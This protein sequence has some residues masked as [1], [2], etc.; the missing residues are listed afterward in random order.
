MRVP[1]SWLREFAPTDM[2]ADEL[3]DLITS[4]GVKVEAVLRPWE[5]L[6]GVVVARVIEVRDHPNSQ[7]LCLV[8]V[9]RGGGELELVAGIRN[10]VAG[11]LVPLAPP[12][13]RVPVLDE[14]LG[15]RE[16]RGA[17]SNGM[18]C[19]SREL[20]ISPDHG[21]IL[22]LN[23]EKLRPG[24]DLKQAL[25][26]DDAVLDIEVEPNRPDF[27]S[28]FGVA[29]EV[30]AMAGVALKPPDLSLVEDA[31][32]ASSVASVRLDAPD[33]C[34]RYVGRILRGIGA[35][36]TPISAQA[37][38]TAA[39]MRPLSPVVDATNYTMLELGQP[40]HAFDLQGLAGPGIVVRRAERGERLTTLDG[41]DRTMSDED[42]LICDLKEPVALAGVMGGATSEVCATTTDV[43]LEAA[44]FTRTGILRTARRL[45]LH[46]EASHRFERGSDR[47]ALD[48]AGTR[49]AG[50]IAAWTGARVLAGTA[51]A[52][53]VQE[54]GW[55]S[56]R[57]ERASAL[58]GHEVTLDQ[59][60]AVFSELGLASRPGAGGALEVEIPGYRVDIEREVDLIEEIA[61]MR[62]YDEIG[63]TLPD[64][65]HVG[66]LPEPYRFAREVKGA[67]LRAGLREVRPLPFASPEDLA[68]TGDEDGIELSNP[69]RAEEGFMRTRL[70]PGLLH[71]I[72][73]NQALGVRSLSLFEVSTVFRAGDPI[74]ER[75]KIAFAM[76]GKAPTAWWRPE[77][78]LDALDIKGVLTSLMQEVRVGDWRLGDSLG[79]PFH[80][81]RSAEIL[82]RGE[83]AG[84]MGEIHPRLAT[85][86]GIAGRAA[87]AELEFGA[88]MNAADRDFV[89]RDVPRLPPVRRDLA[90][91]V[92]ADV[93]AGT[94][95]E[96][97]RKAGGQSL[98][99]CELFDVFWG[100]PMPAGFKSLAF[101]LEFRDPQRTLTDE[102]ADASIEAIVGQ[103]ASE[104]GGQLRAG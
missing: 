71:T 13:S 41:V 11:D 26:L 32:P 76:S 77:R 94:V 104:F 51:E 50:L 69:L 84:V 37:R 57:P 96:A 19:S 8:R 78:E 6:A 66:G 24:D 97:I 98:D 31:E 93:A 74:D 102:E 90:F 81:A 82:L 9:D 103:I 87:V 59:A 20:A 40:I 29:R 49:C 5:G 88:V 14:P 45:D 91:V 16:I 42:L 60:E 86:L 25:G 55:M 15:A 67:L 36:L 54:R 21:G 63:S 47:E 62:G 1:L 17:I 18:L 34:P 79:G 30:S 52:G 75:R 48:A 72:A 39:G 85:E 43:L 53:S 64:S 89:F 65:D 70:T 92:P 95:L 99:R 58:L 2:G 23:D 38:L 33:G 80:P 101:S 68:I 12:G 83:R 3:A 61:R 35:G 28:V 44:Y 10:M 73:R 46:T 4:K 7:K 22:I 100:D 27:L 56:V